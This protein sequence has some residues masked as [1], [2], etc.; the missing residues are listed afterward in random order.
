MIV[1]L[2]AHTLASDG[3]DTP[4]QLVENADAAGVDV[5]AITDHDTTAGWTEAIDAATRLG[6]GLLPGIEISCSAGGVSVHLLGYLHDAS[7][8]ALRAELDAARESR[9]TRARRITELLAADVPITWEDVLAQV[10]EGATVGRPHIADA[11]IANGVVPDREAAFADYL[12]TGS[13]YYARHYAPDPVEAV[14]LVRA[15]GGVP[16]MAHPFAEKR[17]RVVPDRIIAD[18]AAAGL[19]ALEAHHP[20]HTPEQEVRAVALAADLSLLTTG[21]S[22]YHGTGKPQGLGA[23]TTSP[24]VLDA[25]LAEPTHRGIVRP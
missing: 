20:D 24:E 12:Y 3:T 13:P 14:R 5:V 11:L 2:H 22:D 25:L 19:F 4:T 8:E 6:V 23:R 9:D 15:A 7:D 21:S 18:M 17:G 1:D 10:A 16:V